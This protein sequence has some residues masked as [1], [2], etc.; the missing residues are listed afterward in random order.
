M[1]VTY[2]TGAL[3]AADR[4]ERRMWARHQALLKLREVPTVPAPVVAQAWRGGSRQALLSRL[5]AGCTVEVLDDVGAR[6]TGTLATQ[7]ATDDV[8]DACVVE[9]ALRRRDLVVSADPGD[10]TTI[11]NATGRALEVEP[12]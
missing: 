6:A 7:A 1:G 8:V 10:L 3:I 2:D 11:A 12:P 4:G 5:L 9:G